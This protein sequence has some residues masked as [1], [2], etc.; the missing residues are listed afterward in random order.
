MS[1]P[2]VF[3]S[4]QRVRPGMLEAYGEYYREVVAQV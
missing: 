1:G 2:T 4:N 3:I